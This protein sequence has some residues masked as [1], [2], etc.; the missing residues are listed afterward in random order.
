LKLINRIVRRDGKSPGTQ[1]RKAWILLT[2]LAVVGSIGIGYLALNRPEA[3]SDFS[4]TKL[5]HAERLALQKKVRFAMQP[6]GE[7]FNP[8]DPYSNYRQARANLDKLAKLDPRTKRSRYFAL[9]LFEVCLRLRD[10]PCMKENA[11]KIKGL[12]TKEDPYETNTPKEIRTKIEEY[13]K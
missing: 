2:V 8:E 1:F 13:A 9:N 3:V 6:T 12:T 10:E 11:R 5:S 7:I 4:E